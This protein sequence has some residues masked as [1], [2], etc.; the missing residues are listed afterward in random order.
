MT[1]FDTS[2]DAPPIEEQQSDPILPE[3][4]FVFELV[5]FERTGPDQYR[6]LGGVKWSFNTYNEDGSPFLFQDEVYCLWRMSNVNAQGQP[7]FTLGTQPNDWAS[8]LLGRPLGVDAQFSVSELRN[9]RMSAMVVWVKQ[10]MDPKKKSISLASLRH[11]PV[12]APTATNGPAPAAAA[13]APAAAAPA[14]PATTSVTADASD[15]DID[16]ALVVTM[17]RKSLKRLKALDTGA[18]AAAQAAVD[19]SD[20]DEADISDLHALSE[21]ISAAVRKAIDD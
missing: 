3:E 13:P 18:G 21:Q 14:R 10:K 20:L 11:V 1:V 19:A 8:A 12:S 16:R 9:K 7:L 5:G 4:R 15:E 17:I 2:L 6:K